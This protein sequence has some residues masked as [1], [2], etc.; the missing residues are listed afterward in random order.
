MKWVRP[1]ISFIFAGGL[2][3]GFFVD[4]IPTEV[5]APVAVGAIV[6]WYTSRD[7]EKSNGQS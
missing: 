1:I 6:W 5:F 2:I 3:A 4:K 7:K